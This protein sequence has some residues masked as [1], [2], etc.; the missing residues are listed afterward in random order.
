[1]NEAKTI[2]T[3][4]NLLADFLREFENELKNIYRPY[5]YA[6]EDVLPA[7]R[8]TFCREKKANAFKSDCIDFF[9]SFLDTA[10]PSVNEFCPSAKIFFDSQRGNLREILSQQLDDIVRRRSSFDGS[11]IKPTT[12]SVLSGPLIVGL[13]LWYL[14]SLSKKFLVFDNWIA[15]ET[16]D[17]MKKCVEDIERLSLQ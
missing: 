7:W 2:E 12:S 10:L 14:D 15:I 13:G 3:I 9:F 17:R 4:N 11:V 6:K 5:K 16:R 8:A 1:M